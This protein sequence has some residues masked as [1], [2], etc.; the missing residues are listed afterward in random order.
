[1]NLKDLKDK[2]GFVS[3]KPVRKDVIWSRKVDGEEVSDTF[4]IHV[5][6][7]SYGDIERIFVDPKDQDR[8]RTAALLAESVLLGD[9]GKERLSYTDA[10][11]LAPSLAAALSKAVS[12]V[13]ALKN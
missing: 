11:Q 5:R 4:T 13:N 12:E 1:M 6:P 10:Y 2:G 8:S 3:S 9:E 7:M